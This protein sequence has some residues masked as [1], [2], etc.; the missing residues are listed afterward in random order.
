MPNNNKKLAK[1]RKRRHLQR[2]QKHHLDHKLQKESIL[3]DTLE[4]QI[5]KEYNTKLYN[6][7]TDKSVINSYDVI[8]EIPAI[9]SSDKSFCII[10]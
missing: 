8:S 9:D 5:N 4:G 6:S 10:C 7:E 1:R 2:I 3:E